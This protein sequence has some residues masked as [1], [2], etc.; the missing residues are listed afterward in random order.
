MDAASNAVNKLFTSKSPVVEKETTHGTAKSDI[1]AAPAVSSPGDDVDTTVSSKVAP[2]VEHEHIKKQHETREQTF[3]EKEKHKDHYHT[4]IQ[5]LKDSAVRPEKHDYVQETE[6]RS[7]DHDNDTAKQKQRQIE[8][9]SK[10]QARRR[11]LS[12]QQRSQRWARSTYI[13]TC[14]RLCS[15]AFADMIQIE[16]IDPSVTHKKVNIKE[17]HQEP[18]EHHGVTTKS[19]IS[20]D[21]FKN[22]LDEGEDTSTVV[23]GKA[24]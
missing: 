3:V 13:I 24:V 20:V 21:D 8:Q 1:N 15:L 12:L 16:V 19:A 17:T 22:K 6:H 11:R 9:A 2:A 5:P 23:K 4:T 14:M 18:S 10:A 7:F